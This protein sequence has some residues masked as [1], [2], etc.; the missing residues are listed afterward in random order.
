MYIL[1]TRLGSRPRREKTCPC[2]R[3]VRVAT[4]I[5]T[6]VGRCGWPRVVAPCWRAAGQRI[7]I[8]TAAPAIAAALARF[9]AFIAR[10]LV[11]SLRARAA[12]HAHA[13]STVI[14]TTS[15]VNVNSSHATAPARDRSTIVGSSAT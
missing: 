11:S 1:Y 14:N 7:A 2:R 12:S 13:Q 8:A 4:R 15:S 6:C 10:R 3:W 9:A 5:L